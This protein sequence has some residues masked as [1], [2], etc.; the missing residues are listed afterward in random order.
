M[1][2]TENL[3]DSE[4]VQSEIKTIKLLEKK[5]K[6]L[7]EWE[8][9]F[10][11][12]LNEQSKQISL[13]LERKTGVSFNERGLKNTKIKIIDFGFSEVYISTNISIDQYY[14]EDNKDSLGK[15]LDY[16]GRICNTRKRQKMNFIEVESG[17]SSNE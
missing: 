9:E 4:L 10:D 12:L 7:A 2:D 15:V 3:K 14:N 11:V 8:K 13:L 17:K 1:I 16:I 5:R 6:L